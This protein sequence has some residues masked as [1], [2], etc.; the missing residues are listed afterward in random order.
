[1]RDRMAAM[2]AGHDRHLGAIGAA[3]TE[4]RIDRAAR[5]LGRAP[6]Q[7]PVA[8]LEPA[9]GAMGG[10][11]LGQRL[12]RGIRLGHH[13]QAGGI[14]V[15]AMHDA[16]PLHAADA[17]QA[18]AAVRQQ[19]IDERT[20]GMAGARMGRH[21]FRLVDDDQVRV[22][23]DDPERDRLRLRLCRNRRRHMHLVGLAGPDLA[24]QSGDGFA[25]ARHLAGADQRLQARAAELGQAQRQEAIQAL[26]G[27]GLFDGSV[28]R[29]STVGPNILRSRDLGGWAWH[30]KG[31][32]GCLGA[33]GQMRPDT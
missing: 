7:R 26:A 13:Q 10:E 28:S 11:L 17:G 3:A 24:A 6:D 25:P 12:M 15:E 1:M 30:R 22:L 31:A 21:A 20:R 33:G 4:P 2:L 19:R 32:T 5:P 14:L 16:R 29:D 18:V 27:L 8:A 23:V 9:V